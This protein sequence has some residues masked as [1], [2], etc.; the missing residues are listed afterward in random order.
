LSVC[1]EDDA[2]ISDPPNGS[3]LR[4]S[5]IESHAAARE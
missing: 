3:M 1:T 2:G 5:M 4:I